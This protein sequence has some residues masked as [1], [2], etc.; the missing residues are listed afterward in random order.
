[1]PTTSNPV[2]ERLRPFALRLPEAQEDFPWGERVFKVN[3]K[4]FI[5]MGLPHEI[6]KVQLTVKLP[7]SGGAVL[8]MPFATAA[9]YG[10]GAS[11]WVWPL[12]KGTRNCRSIC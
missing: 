10:L 8:L 2:T 3:K 1:M 7:Q 4:V 11:G 12:L 9:Y 6:D 5:F